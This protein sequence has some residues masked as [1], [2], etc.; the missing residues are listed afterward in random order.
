[1][2]KD[3]VH[4]YMQ[5]LIDLGVVMGHKCS[6]TSKTLK[7]PLANH[8]VLGDFR[9]VKRLI[10]FGARADGLNTKGWTPLMLAAFNG[11]YDI[12]EYLVNLGVNVNYKDMWGDTALILAS[13]TN[14]SKII[15]LL[16]E[17]GAV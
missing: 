10:E 13:E 4:K 6:V 17:S 16:K 11:K 9:A 5:E 1:M 7:V 15:K 3:D 12:A 2:K 14:R 8:I